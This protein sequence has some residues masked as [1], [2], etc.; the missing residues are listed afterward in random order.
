MTIAE[1]KQALL[2]QLSAI[3]NSQERF[4]HL[5]SLA[6]QQP[7]LEPEF[8]TD[9]YRVEGCLA[10]LW[11]VATFRDGRCYFRTD[12]D[13]AI[14]KSVAALLAD[15]YSG[16]TPKEILTTDPSFLETVGISQHLTQNRRN[17]L[18]KVWEKIRAFAGAHADPEHAGT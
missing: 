17:S 1:K 11:F 13:S 9:A 18:G 14:V 4:A 6:R 5:I 7:P 12:S 16:Q 8:K 15:F 3:K 10:K 2:A